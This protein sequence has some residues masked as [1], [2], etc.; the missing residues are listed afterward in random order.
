MMDKVIDYIKNYR[1]ENPTGWRKWIFGTVVAALT[2]LVVGVLAFQAAQRAKELSSLQVQRDQARMA[3]Q[4][5]EI[6]RKLA[7]TA[8][9]RTRHELAAHEAMVAQEVLSS[10]IE[11]LEREHKTSEEVIN[12]IRSWEDVDRV[13]K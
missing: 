9:D 3:L 10:Q 4:K 7:A 2:L 13:V 11:R 5:A 6:D 1:E 8:A 12:S